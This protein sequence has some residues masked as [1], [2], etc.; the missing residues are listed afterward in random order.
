[1]TFHGFWNFSTS[2]IPTG[3]GNCQDPDRCVGFRLTVPNRRFR[4]HRFAPFRTSKFLNLLW[5]PRFGG[6]T[7]V[8]IRLPKTQ[9]RLPHHV[10]TLSDRGRD[11]I[12]LSFTS[13]LFVPSLEC[14]QCRPCCQ[15]WRPHV[16]EKASSMAGVGTNWDRDRNV[17]AST[18][19]QTRKQHEMARINLS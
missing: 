17:F 15:I 4:I 10:L 12:T 18:Q 9:P 5:G 1:M 11:R 19:L 8:A 6:Q 13:D 14:L 3:K 2:N 16:G 7:G